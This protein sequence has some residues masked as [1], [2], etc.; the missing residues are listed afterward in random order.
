MKVSEFD[1][2]FYEKKG[3]ISHLKKDKCTHSILELCN[4]VHLKL[5]ATCM[6]LALTDCPSSI[7]SDTIDLLFSQR[8]F[9]DDEAHNVKNIFEIQNDKTDNNNNKS[10]TRLVVVEFSHLESK[11]SF[12]LLYLN[13]YRYFI[14]A[15]II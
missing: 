4:F 1:I 7:D 2:E 8:K 6:M 12:V 13:K 11:G 10:S 15:N 3:K 5:G 9:C 14:M